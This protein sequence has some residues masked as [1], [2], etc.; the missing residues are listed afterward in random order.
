MKVIFCV[1][2][3]L[4]E[5]KKNLTYSILKKQIVKGLEKINNFENIIIA[6]EPVWSIGTGLVPKSSELKKNINSI[7]KI[8]SLLRKSKKINILYGGSV[9]PDNA[10]DLLEMVNING[11]LVG[12]ASLNAK[13]FIDI[14]KKSIN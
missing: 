10:K 3:K 13:K 4:N 7:K 2:E 14:I 6:Y 9:S 11:F 1:G 12:G 5:K 8:L